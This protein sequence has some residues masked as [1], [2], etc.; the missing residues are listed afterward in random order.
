MFVVIL[1][2]LLLAAVFG[3]LGAVLQAVAFLVLTAVL[4]AVVLGALAWWG[5]KRKVREFQA[6]VDKQLTEQRVTRYRVNEAER[7]PSALPPQHDD[8]Y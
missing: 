6:E 5:L 4:T 3:V 7:D 2:L 1:I 8:R